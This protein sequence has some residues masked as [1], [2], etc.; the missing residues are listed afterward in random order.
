MTKKIITAPRTDDPAE[1]R[2]FM[3]NVANAINSLVCETQA[4]STASDVAGI[5]ADVNS[6]LAK[7]RDSI[8]Q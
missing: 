6:L 8:I 1:M 5:V 2:R 4:D 7:L 3:A